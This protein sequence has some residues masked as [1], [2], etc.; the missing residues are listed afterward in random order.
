MFL[1]CVKKSAMTTAWLLTIFVLMSL[2]SAKSTVASTNLNGMVVDSEGAGIAKAQIVVRPDASGRR[3][4]NKGENI[5]LESDKQGRFSTQLP[6]GFYDLCVMADAFSPF[7]QKL[8]VNKAA[9]TPKI[10]LKADPDVMKRLGD[11]F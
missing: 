8:F 2:F 3:I 9:L 7:C 11:V 10:E 6:P 5:M 4:A 1:E